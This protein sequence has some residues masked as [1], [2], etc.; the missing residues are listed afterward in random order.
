MVYRRQREYTVGILGEAFMKETPHS[1]VPSNNEKLSYK[2][3][4]DGLKERQLRQFEHP[5]EMDIEPITP[6]EDA[7][8]AEHTEALVEARLCGTEAEPEMEPPVEIEMSEAYEGLELPREKRYF[9][10][11]EVSE[12]IGVEPYVLRYWEGEFKL[13]RPEKSG[14]GHRVYSRKDV[15]TLHRIRHLLHVEKFS[16][17][18]AKKKLLEKRRETVPTVLA[19][20]LKRREEVLKGVAH[21]LKSLLHFAR[22]NNPGG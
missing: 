19:S 14:A 5:P 2:F 1:E 20:D 15:E 21:D 3:I 22:D 17:K 7:P 9:R 10:I 16:I 18:G 8:L 13:L 12:L 6:V 11:G 4:L